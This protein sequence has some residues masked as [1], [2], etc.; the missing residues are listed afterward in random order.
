MDHRE[1]LV[2]QPCL[3]A[4]RCSNS[5]VFCT[6]SLFYSF[7]QLKRLSYSFSCLSC[8]HNTAIFVQ[9]SGEYSGVMGWR[10]QAPFQKQLPRT[11][12]SP[13]LPPH[14]P[15][16]SVATVRSIEHACCFLYDQLR[17]GMLE[18]RPSPKNG[19]GPGKRSPRERPIC[20]RLLSVP[21]KPRPAGGAPTDLVFCLNPRIFWP[22]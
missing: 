15:P 16:A 4:I 11:K 9:L 10:K 21:I 1:A 22:C 7:R 8:R 12:R 17:R 3:R 19:N 20:V 14:T 6:A 18:A 2:L 5:R 13:T